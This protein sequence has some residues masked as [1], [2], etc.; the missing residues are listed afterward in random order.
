MLVVDLHTLRAVHLL[1]LIDQV[2]LGGAHAA[3]LEHLL[4]IQR[5]LGELIAGLDDIAIGEPQP[6]AAGERIFD[7]AVTSLDD[8]APALL[9]IDHTDRATHL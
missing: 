1:H 7:I 9:V 3:D 6:R 5:T 2:L 8:G 4:R